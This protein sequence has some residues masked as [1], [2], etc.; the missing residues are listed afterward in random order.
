MANPKPGREE[1]IAGLLERSA[2]IIRAS[3][4]EHEFRSLR[5]PPPYFTEADID[6]LRP[7]ALD[8][9]WNFR[10]LVRGNCL[11]PSWNQP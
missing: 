4:I 2:A 7:L 8:S 1:E 6:S 5:L 3:G 9:L 11:D 10:P